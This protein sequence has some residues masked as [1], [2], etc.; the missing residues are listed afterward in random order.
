MIET[1]STNAISIS[2]SDD[3]QPD[4]PLLS[5]DEKKSSIEP[6]LLLVKTKPITSSLRA[7][8]S[9]LRSKAGCL[10]R[11]RGLHISLIFH[12]F[13]YFLFR[14][15]LSLVG[16]EFASPIRQPLV[17][18][19]ASVLLSRL[20]MHWTHHVISMPSTKGWWSRRPSRKLW[21]KIAGPT[22][23]AA[24]VE[25]ITIWMP[26]SLFY[27]F[28]LDE[29]VRDTSRLGEISEH[30]RRIIFAK[31]MTVCVVGI[32]TAVLIYIPANVTLKRVQASMLAEE[33]ETIVPF[34][35]T[36]DGK[37][38]A[39]IT[40][41]SGRL[42]MLDAW[43]TF[44]WAARIRLMKVYGKVFA[45]QTAVTIMFGMMLVAEMKLIMGPMFT[46]LVAGA[47]NDA[48]QGGSQQPVYIN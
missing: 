42:G 34:D 1:P 16:G 20:G 29:Y 15:I 30:E 11:F 26:V 32:L 13:H 37:V 40:G 38:K 46:K 35:R 2:V 10:S 36:F 24:M 3:S 19:F 27:I 17:A 33:E 4:A 14:T 22:A 8:I 9:H 39:E 48:V 5:L 23:L 18:V 43:K 6:E 21:K 7:T 44:D 28:G 47:Y 41:G 45:V 25:Q 12:V 31:F